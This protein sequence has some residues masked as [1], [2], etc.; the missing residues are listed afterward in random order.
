MIIGTILISVEAIAGLIFIVRFPAVSAPGK[1]N[2]EILN[3][4][5]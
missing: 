1:I 3:F 2:I 4:N 5:I